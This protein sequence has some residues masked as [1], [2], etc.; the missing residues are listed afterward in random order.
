M[1]LNNKNPKYTL[2]YVE[3]EAPIRMVTKMFLEPYFTEIFEAQDGV[4]AF[5]IYEEE[6]PNVIIT[7]IEMPKMDGLNLC[8]K[9]R[10]EDNETPIII[11]TAYTSVE[12]LLEA[13]SLNLIK[14]LGKPLKE[15][16]VLE[17]LEN[18]FEQLESKNPSIVQLTDILYYDTFNQSLS[19]EK[20][21]ISLSQYQSMLLNILIKN[22][23]RI[24]S[25]TEIENEIW[26]DKVMTADS[27]RTLVRKTRK[28]VGKE[29]IENISKTGY[30]INLYG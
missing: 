27:L 8:R 30:R 25:Y 29:I 1:T 7:D 28:L 9:I 17:A 22:K 23:N 16:E 24:V 18:C 6:K 4:E 20:K 14:Y 15:E 10:K 26:Y 3:D 5:Q 12:Y 19:E 21:L 11:T 13:V 2:L